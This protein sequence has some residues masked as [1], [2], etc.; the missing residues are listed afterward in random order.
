[1]EKQRRE[2]VFRMEF[3]GVILG[4]RK[5]RAV[6]NA[7]ARCPDGVSCDIPYGTAMLRLIPLFLI[8]LVSSGAGPKPAT[9]DTPDPA[10]SEMY[11]KDLE[12][13]AAAQ[14]KQRA[15]ACRTLPRPSVGMSESS[16]LASCWGKPEHKRESETA[17]GKQ[18][19]WG[20]PEGYLYFTKGLVT[21]IITPR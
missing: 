3:N 14:A 21:R 8:V 9:P 4:V 12:E 18:A 5:R 6:A 15:A 13:E 10:L 2:S 16:V 17:G 1:M 11:R 19:V 20:Y 7:C